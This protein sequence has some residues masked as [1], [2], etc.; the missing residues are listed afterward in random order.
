[1]NYTKNIPFSNLIYYEADRLST[2]ASFT[3]IGSGGL[4]SWGSDWNGSQSTCFNIG[5]IKIKLSN[6][7][8][9]PTLPNGTQIQIKVKSRSTY[10]GAGT[11]K[12]HV[13]QT[14]F[15][16]VTEVCNAWPFEVTSNFSKTVK[17]VCSSKYGFSNEATGEIATFTGTVNNINTSSSVYIYF[18]DT[19]FNYGEPGMTDSYFSN[20]YITVSLIIPSYTLSTKLGPGANITVNRLSSEYGST[21]NLSNG[22]AI[23]YNDTLNITYNISEHYSFTATTLNGANFASNYNITVTNNISI[24]LNTTPDQFTLTW[25][26][27]IGLSVVVN[28][29]STDHPTA[30]TGALSQGNLVYYNDKLSISY[31]VLPGY[32]FNSFKINNNSFNSGSVITITENTIISGSTTVLSYTLSIEQDQNVNISVKRISSPKGDASIGLLS[33]GETIYYS[34]ILEIQV[35]ALSGY[36]VESLLVNEKE[37]ASGNTIEVSENINIS[38]TSVFIGSA[39]ISIKIY[40]NHSK[41]WQPYRIKIYHNG[42]WYG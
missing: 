16:D 4:T 2:K 22:A 40:N 21:G 23:F 30:K 12:G 34:D 8:L 35:A 37:I 42:K 31:S 13:S 3:S 20:S 26:N 33:N 29:N 1:M 38:S 15:T 25:P 18:V 14:N 39:K 10:M 19:V 9:A 7:G 36:L 27:I 28:R 41:T 6:L 32:K 5:K 24:I 11:I 17:G